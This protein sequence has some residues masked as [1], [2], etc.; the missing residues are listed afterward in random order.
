[1]GFAVTAIE[2]APAL[3]ES[4]RQAMAAAPPRL[5]FVAGDARV[6]L[7]S[8]ERP[9]A[10]YLDPMYAETRRKSAPRKD[11]VLLRELVGDDTDAPE[12]LEIALR[13]ARLRVVVKRPRKAAPLRPGV[14]HAYVGASTRFDLYR[15]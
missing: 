12:L 10:V 6:L 7:P 15:I 14:S 2:R 4:W 11:L 3:I 13:C 5:A 8:S 9:D 1:M